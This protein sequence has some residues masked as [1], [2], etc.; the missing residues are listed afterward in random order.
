MYDTYTHSLIHMYSH[1]HIHIHINIH[2]HIRNQSSVHSKCTPQLTLSS[3]TL[4]FHRRSPSL[5][6]S[7][8][9][10]V[11]SLS[12]RHVNNSQHTHQASTSLQSLVVL[13]TSNQVTV[14]D[15]T[16]YAI[17]FITKSSAQPNTS[18]LFCFIFFVQIRV[19]YFVSLSYGTCNSLG[20]DIFFWLKYILE[21]HLQY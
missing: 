17:H 5:I 20:R 9:P 16:S 7:L 19:V 18:K 13:R 10:L 14:D 15:R 21:Y 4:R 2:A 3:L 6:R 1:N 12:L 11:L 8:S